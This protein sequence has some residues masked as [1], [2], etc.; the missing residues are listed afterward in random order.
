MLAGELHLFPESESSY[1]QALAI[2]PKFDFAY[3]GLGADELHQ[4]HFAAALPYFKKLSER[5]P[6]SFIGPLFMSACAL[7][8]GHKAEGGGIWKR[9]TVLDPAGS[10][11][12]VQLARAAR[13]SGPP[14]GNARGDPASGRV[15][16][17]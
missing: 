2:D 7:S 6:K 8:M 13:A 11:N 16:T 3:F 1:Q 14:A 5:E 4:N 15:V 9:A 12:W 17:R 10:V